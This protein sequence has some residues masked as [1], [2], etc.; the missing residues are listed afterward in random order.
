MMMSQ[1][2]ALTLIFIKEAGLTKNII[3]RDQDHPQSS[4]HQSFC[5]QECE[6]EDE[7]QF[8]PLQRRY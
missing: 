4:S 5:L 7:R 3:I 8:V 6:D 1:R 2:N